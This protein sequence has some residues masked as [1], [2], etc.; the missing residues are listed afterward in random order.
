MFNVVL[1]HL[2]DHIMLNENGKERL[3]N[4]NKKNSI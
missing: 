1:F 3:Y 4:I 2:T